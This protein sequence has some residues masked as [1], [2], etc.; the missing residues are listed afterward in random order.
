MLSYLTIREML[1]FFVL[2]SEAIVSAN[3]YIVT[4]NYKKNTAVNQQ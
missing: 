4:K 3:F 2:V 1:V